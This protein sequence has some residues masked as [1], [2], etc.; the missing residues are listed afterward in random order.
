MIA[1][2]QRLPWVLTSAAIVLGSAALSFRPAE[3]LSA[4]IVVVAVGTI[5]MLAPLPARPATRMDARSSLMAV[6]LGVLAFGAARAIASPP[7]TPVAAFAVGAT[8][9]AAFAE[10]V[11]FRRLVYGWLAGAGD[12]LA[13]VG[14]AALFAVVHLPAYGPR[15]LPLDL[16]AGILFGWQRWATGGWVVPAVTHATAN[17]MQLF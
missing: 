17:V 11:F 12:P 16:A 5:G 15:V 8:I 3:P 6:A 1:R 2:G 14:A 13:I 9:V 4:L 7:P 10:E